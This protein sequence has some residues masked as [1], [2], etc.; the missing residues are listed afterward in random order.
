MTGA[1]L[2]RRASSMVAGV[3]HVGIG[4][5]FDGMS[6]AP[7]GLEDVSKYPDLF[8]ELARRGWTDGELEKLA[9]RNLLRALRAAEAVARRLQAT[10]PPSP[11]T[12]EQLDGPARKRDR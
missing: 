12:L 7:I 10:R 5:D 6:S 4:G 2:T 11:A 8:A 9:G 1:S 3:D